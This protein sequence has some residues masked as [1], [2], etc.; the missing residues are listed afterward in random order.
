MSRPIGANDHAWRPHEH[1][2]RLI[3]GIFAVTVHDDGLVA[4]L[5]AVAV[6]AVV[7]AVAVKSGEARFGW[8]VVDATGGEEND[9]GGDAFLV[10]R[11]D[12]KLVFFSVDRADGG[13]ADRHVRIGVELLAADGAELDGMRAVAREI[14][15][16]GSREGVAWF[17][18]VEDEHTA[19]AAAEKES[20]AQ[21]GG[22][23]ADDAYLVCDRCV[24]RRRRRVGRA[25]HGAS[26]RFAE[27]KF[28]RGAG[29]REHP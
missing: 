22:A 16:K 6:G 3:E 25:G 12:F 2:Q 24:A 26:D 11:D 18:G 1:E 23:A 29:G 9:A 15:V 7:N 5:P 19:A 10:N 4:V 13:V 28:V 20:S 17:A 27:V 21:A 8:H 14:A